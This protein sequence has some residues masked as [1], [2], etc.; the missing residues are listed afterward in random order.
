[1]SVSET[2]SPT[3]AQSPPATTI[4]PSSWTSKIE[5]VLLQRLLIVGVLSVLIMIGL[6]LTNVNHLRSR[7]YWS[8]MFPIFWIVC[9]WH[10]LNGPCRHE[11][12]IWKRILRQ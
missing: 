7:F 11:L 1:M 2:E 12:P 3:V 8:A 9:V 4:T 5:S 6:F 10:E